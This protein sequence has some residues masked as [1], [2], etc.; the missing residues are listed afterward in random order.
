MALAL[1]CFAVASLLPVAAASA[2][3]GTF[4]VSGQAAGTLSET[5]CLINQG[6]AVLPFDNTDLKVNGHSVAA[7]NL[8]AS[9]HVAAFGVSVKIS[10]KNTQ[11]YVTFTFNVGSKVYNWQSTSGT[12]TTKSKGNGGSFKTTLEPQSGTAGGATKSVALSGSW[13]SCG[14][15]AP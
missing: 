12:I 4:K 3:A 14:A 1:G 2:S 6:A 8:I 10:P 13:S 9:A 15:G 7:T 11:N 5:T